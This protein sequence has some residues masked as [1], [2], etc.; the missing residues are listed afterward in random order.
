MTKVKFYMKVATL[1][2]AF[3]LG[4]ITAIVST[5]AFLEKEYF[6]QRNA[7]WCLLDESERDQIYQQYPVASTYPK[8]KR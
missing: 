3:M 6:S 1:I 8:G 2:A 7:M 4:W 5:V